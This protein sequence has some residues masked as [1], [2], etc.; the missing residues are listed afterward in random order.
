MYTF[1]RLPLTHSYAFAI[2]KWYLVISCVRSVRCYWHCCSCCCYFKSVCIFLIQFIYL[3]FSYFRAQIFYYAHYNTWLR[4]TCVNS[5]ICV[6]CYSFFY[7]LSLS[8]SLYLA[9]LSLPLSISLSFSL[10]LF[11]ILFSILFFSVLSNLVAVYLIFGVLLYTISQCALH[12]KK[13]YCHKYRI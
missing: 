9:S 8:F 6:A 13:Y 11:S 5:T 7:F 4:V 10:F 1:S 3:F 12:T 2:S